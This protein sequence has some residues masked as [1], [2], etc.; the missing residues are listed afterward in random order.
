M[1]ERYLTFS[2][3]TLGDVINALVIGIEVC[4]KALRSTCEMTLLKVVT[5]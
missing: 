2:L 1:I 4:K 5:P 3:K